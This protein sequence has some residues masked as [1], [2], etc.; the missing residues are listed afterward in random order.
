MKTIKTSG[1]RTFRVPHMALTAIALALAPVSQTM[2][3]LMLEEVVVTAQKRPQ[4]LQDVPV[5]IAAVSGEKINDLGITNLEEIT[6]Y[7][8]NVNINK[9][10]ASPNIFIRGIGS[11]TGKT[12]GKG[13]KGQKARSGVSLLGFEGGQMPLYR[14][15]PKRGFKNIFRKSYRLVNLG[16]LQQEID[17]G[18]L[19]ASAPITEKNLQEAGIVKTLRDGVRVLAN[20]EIK[21]KI[22]L[23]VSGAS[24]SA[25]AAI[26]S[27]GGSVVIP[28]PAVETPKAKDKAGD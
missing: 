21:S 18:K 8:P 4:G 24:K 15:L 7:T 17:A 26:E 20:G 3:Q 27:A 12:S 6:L 23:E 13:H 1:R 5:A 2:A 22:Q 16:R 10:Q 11:G 25:V 19:D 9:G 28:A 14:R